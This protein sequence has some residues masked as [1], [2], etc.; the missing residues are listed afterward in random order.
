MKAA[1]ISG[2]ILTL[3]LLLIL[4]NGL[5]VTHTVN[6]MGEMVAALPDEPGEAAVARIEAIA[7]YLDDKETHLSFS[8]PFALL[9][10]GVELC[11]VLKAYAVNGS[12]YDYAATKVSLADAVKDMG[13]L[14][15]LQWKNI[16]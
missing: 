12:I 13:R 4:M 5:F 8:V 10:R 15:K 6:T 14:E 2:V 3:V 7:E 9:D 16:F 1:V 11:R